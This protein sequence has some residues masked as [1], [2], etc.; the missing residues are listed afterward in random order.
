MNGNIIIEKVRE[1]GA[2]ATYTVIKGSSR[3]PSLLIC[4]TNIAGRNL[5]SKTNEIE[6]GLCRIDEQY[7]LKA[8]TPGNTRM[9][10]SAQGHF[11]APGDF[12]PYAEFNESDSGDVLEL[13]A[14]GYI[15]DH[16]PQLAS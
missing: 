5:G 9:T 13:C 8:E 10:T 15:V 1:V 3:N 7:I 6:I 16:P 11:Y 12:V 14:Y 4:W 2:G